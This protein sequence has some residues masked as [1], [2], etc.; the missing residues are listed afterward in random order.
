MM[1]ADFR[2]VMVCLNSMHMNMTE[3]SS[4]E[5]RN[6]LFP[7]FGYLY[8]EG[9]DKL[10]KAGTDPSMVETALEATDGTGIYKKCYDKAKSFYENQDGDIKGHSSIED[11]MYSENVRAYELAFEQQY[12][13]GIFYAWV[14]LKEQEIRNI[15]WIASMIQLSGK[16]HIDETIIPIF[17]PRA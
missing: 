3:E 6:Q 10:R 5:K 14:K 16:E 11:V 9:Y 13:F 1:E 12:H 8:P 15:K 4:I 7:H 2:V 17:E